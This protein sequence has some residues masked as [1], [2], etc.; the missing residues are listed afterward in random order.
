MQKPAFVFDGRL[1]LD[2]Q[3]LISIGFN[4]E[5]IGKQTNNDYN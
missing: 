3:N 1:L 2:H 5:A 4:V